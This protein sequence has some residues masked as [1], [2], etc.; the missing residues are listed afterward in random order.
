[1]TRAESGFY[2]VLLDN[3]KQ[4]RC[5][6]RGRMKQGRADVVSLVTIGDRVRLTLAGSEEGNVEEVLPRRTE[7]V[8]RAAGPG[9]KRWLRQALAANLDLLIVVTSVVAPEFNA[10]R[11]DRFLVVAEDAGIPPAICLN[12]CDLATGQEIAATLSPFAKTDYPQILTSVVTG[13]GLDE[14]RA[15]LGGHRAAFVGVSGAGKSSLLNALLPG[16]GQRTG[17]VNSASGRG[18]HTTTVA[19]LLPLD[20]ETWLADTPGLREL[21]PWGLQHDRLPWLFPEIR[22]VIAEP[23]RFP[24]C[25]HRTEPGCRVLAAVQAGRM[26]QSRHQSYVKLWDEAE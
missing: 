4:L 8:R 16:A 26:A 13:Q 5:R 1:M 22:A 11:L 3:G 2:T 18:R 20:K 15:L 19:Q 7:L 10:A 6:L 17:D 21:S 25:T 9:R 23:C 14:L 24:A 12:K